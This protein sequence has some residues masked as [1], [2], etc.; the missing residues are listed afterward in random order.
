MKILDTTIRDGSYAVDFK[1][2]LGDVKSVVSKLSRLNIELI[3]IG[4]GQGLNASS[5]EHGLSLY[6]DEEYIK[7]AVEVAGNSKG[8]S[9]LY[10]R[11]SPI[12]RYKNG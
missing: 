3:E 12:R 6:S 4:H 10:S 1:F 7:A 2:S 9:I 8:G 11:N 5:P